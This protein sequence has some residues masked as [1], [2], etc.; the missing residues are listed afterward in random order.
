MK[1]KSILAGLLIGASTLVAGQTLADTPAISFSSVADYAVQTDLSLGNSFTANTTVTVTALGYYNLTGTGFLTPHEVGI[2]DSAGNLLADTVLPAGS[3]D[4]L[5]GG[6]RYQAIK[7]VT[8]VAGQTY[9]LVGEAE[10]GDPW[11]YA[12]YTGFTVNPAI[13]LGTVSY[14]YQSDNVLRDTLLYGSP[15][16][17]T[18]YSGPNFLI[19]SGV[20]EPASWAMALIGFGLVGAGARLRRRA[21]RAIA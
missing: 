5:I 9:N 16:I 4:P 2:F 14:I 18:A 13:T 17:W 1:T 12:G 7:P 11:G 3:S 21:V 8:L 6:F 10:V 15:Y 20:P 19:S